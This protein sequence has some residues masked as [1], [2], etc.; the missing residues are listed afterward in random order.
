MT[1]DDELECSCGGELELLSDSHGRTVGKC[2]ACGLI[3]YVGEDE[4]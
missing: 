1:G 3:Y 4:A 2:E